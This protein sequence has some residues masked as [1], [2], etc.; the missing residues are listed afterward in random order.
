MRELR[1]DMGSRSRSGRFLS[2]LRHGFSTQNDAAAFDAGT[3]GEEPPGPGGIRLVTLG[4]TGWQCVCKAKGILAEL[5]ERRAVA[6][7]L[8]R[9]GALVLFLQQPIPMT[10]TMFW[11]ATRV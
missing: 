5:R 1:E 10:N 8:T 7:N 2:R 3:R 4:P 6:V 9:F 11:G